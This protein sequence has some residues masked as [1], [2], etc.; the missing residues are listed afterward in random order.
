[1]V[2]MTGF[3]L[4]N[5]DLRSVSNWLYFERGNE[6]VYTDESHQNGWTEEQVV[7]R[8]GKRISSENLG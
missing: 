8:V 4:E 6:L 1:M 3:N 7:K 5:N 2:C